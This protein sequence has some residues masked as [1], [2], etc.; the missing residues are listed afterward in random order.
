MFGQSSTDKMMG[1]N[2]CRANPSRFSI[3]QIPDVPVK[4]VR[5]DHC[6]MEAPLTDAGLNEEA[7]T[8]DETFQLAWGHGQEWAQPNQFDNSKMMWIG[9][10]LAT[11]CSLM[12]YMEFTSTFVP[13]SHPIRKRCEIPIIIATLVTGLICPCTKTK[14]GTSEAAEVKEQMEAQETP[15]NEDDGVDDFGGRCGN[16]SLCSKQKSYIRGEKGEAIRSQLV[17]FLITLPFNFMIA[18]C[19]FSLFTLLNVY[20]GWGSLLVLLS[21]LFFVFSLY[22]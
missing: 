1:V 12:A 18:W 5:H 15:P 8:H 17:Y 7:K 9:I 19:V 20:P 22:Y 21:F 11:L 16:K 6:W 13:P 10:L 4:D 2:P 3:V 14:R